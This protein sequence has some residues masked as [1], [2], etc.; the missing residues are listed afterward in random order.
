MEIRT[1]P[2]RRVDLGREL[3]AARDGIRS[4]PGVDRLTR[5]QS[6]GGRAGLGRARR[7]RSS[8]RDAATGKGGDK[9]Q[10]LKASEPHATPRSDRDRWSIGAHLVTPV[11]QPRRTT[12]WPLV[13][14][15]NAPYRSPIEAADWKG[16]DVKLVN[17]DGMVLFGPGSE[18]FWTALQ[19]T[20][21]AI[22]FIAIYRQLR[23][24]QVQIRDNTK[25][26]RSQ[27]HNNAILLG[28]RPLEMVIEN[29]GLSNIVNVGYMTP[30]ALSEVEWARFGNYTF[31]QV[32]AWEYFYYQHRDG[33]IPKELWVGADA[34]FRGLVRSKPGLARFWSEFQETYDEPFRSHVADEFARKPAPAEQATA[35]PPD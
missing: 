5:R 30:E 26:L 20:A 23:T 27:A 24:Q 1:D 9:E 8:R 10:R 35:A 19:F 18:W 29:E 28:S 34:Y 12:R 21:L 16:A 15:W 4:R 2:L 6:D 14:P 33:S 7:R 32:N 11:A 17:I 25:L 3:Q 13:R 31:L 22:T